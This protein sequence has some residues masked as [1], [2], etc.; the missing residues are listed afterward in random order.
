VSASS[1]N[2]IEDIPYIEMSFSEDTSQTEPHNEVNTPAMKAKETKDI[3]QVE[4]HTE[5]NTSEM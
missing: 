5:V 4:P 1:S 3:A 2:P